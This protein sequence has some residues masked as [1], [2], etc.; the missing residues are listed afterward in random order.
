MKTIILTAII[1]STSSTWA[2]RC[3]MIGTVNDGQDCHRLSTRISVDTAEACEA[4][5]RNTSG[6]R[7]FGLISGKAKLVATEYRFKE[8]GSKKMK[9]EIQFADSSRCD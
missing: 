4:F 5:A 8:R 9:K 6:N 3:H 7:F 1:L 2:G